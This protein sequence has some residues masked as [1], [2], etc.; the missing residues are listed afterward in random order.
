[1]T[2]NPTELEQRITALEQHMELVDRRM[3]AVAFAA[4]QTA[5]NQVG[6]QEILGPWEQ[7]VAREHELKQLQAHEEAVY[8][9]KREQAPA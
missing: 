6:L 4:R 1:V 2:T 9:Q 8:G 3:E 5:G 7:R